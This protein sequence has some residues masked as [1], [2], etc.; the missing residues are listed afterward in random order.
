[1]QFISSGENYHVG[2]Q[3]H[4][5]HTALLAPRSKVVCI[6]YHRGI[7]SAFGWCHWSNYKVYKSDI[8]EC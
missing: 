2:T 8:V 5:A 4:L 7:K 1:M 3:K 6:R